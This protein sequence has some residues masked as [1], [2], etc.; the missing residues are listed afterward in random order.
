MQI[1]L[2]CF[3]KSSREL[4]HQSLGLEQVFRV[5]GVGLGWFLFV[6]VSSYCLIED[7]VGVQCSVVWMFKYFKI[8]CFS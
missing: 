4:P 5:G 7:N 1:L 8:A 6:V 3:R 2:F